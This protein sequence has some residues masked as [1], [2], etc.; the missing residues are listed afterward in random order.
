M[1]LIQADDIN[2]LAWSSRRNIALFLGI[3]YIPPF[4]SFSGLAHIQASYD[5]LHNV[6][7]FR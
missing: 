7:N 4:L 5:E 2:S 1:Y 6:N 3:F